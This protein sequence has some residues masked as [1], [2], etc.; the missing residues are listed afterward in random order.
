MNKIGWF[1]TLCQS[2]GGFIN[3]KKK[4]SSNRKNCQ[5]VYLLYIA[6]GYDN[7]IGYTSS[8]HNRGFQAADF[9]L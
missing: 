4:R 7:V 6:K 1:I 5:L 8:D 3:D 2:H 9:C